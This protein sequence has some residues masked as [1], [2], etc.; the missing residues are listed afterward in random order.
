MNL[1]D[2]AETERD[3]IYFRNDTRAFVYEVIDEN[4][5]VFGNYGGWRVIAFP[6]INPLHHD[7][8][9]YSGPAAWA[10]YR[11]FSTVRKDGELVSDRL[12]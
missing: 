12:I 2:F 5:K 7:F 4:K 9:L 3:T 6:G 11:M 10:K 1:R 8:E